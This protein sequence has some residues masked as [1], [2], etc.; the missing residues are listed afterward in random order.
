[1]EKT[2][3]KAVSP[4]G[5]PLV[6]ELVELGI[7]PP[8]T[9]KFSLVAEVNHAVKIHVERNATKEE[10]DAVMTTILKHKDEVVVDSVAVVRTDALTDTFEK[11]FPLIVK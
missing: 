11:R 10:F 6:R 9:V 7:I 5:S 3:S 1:M 2:A 4:H 8:E